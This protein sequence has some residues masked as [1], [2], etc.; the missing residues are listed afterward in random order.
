MSTSCQNIERKH[1]KAMKIVNHQ[2]LKIIEV[3]M[4]DQIDSNLSPLYSL[5]W[6]KN[7]S[8]NKT[9]QFQQVWMVLI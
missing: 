6:K 9:L 3:M 5:Y 4:Q 2:L 8:K 1:L 7:P